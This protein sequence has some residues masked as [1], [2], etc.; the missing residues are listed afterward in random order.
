MTHSAA[1]PFRFRRSE[2]TVGLTEITSTTETVH[3]L[4]RLEGEL[5]RV[6]W[7][8]DRATERVGMSI[9]TDRE[10]EPVREVVL[11]L[12]ALAGARVAW[13]WWR[14]PPGL[15]LSLNAAD[16]RAFEEIAGEAGLRLDSPTELVLRVR[17]PDRL[18]AQE[19]AAELEM[20][21]AEHALRA[22][23]QPARVEG[24]EAHPPLPPPA[25]ARNETEPA[26]R[27]VPPAGTPDA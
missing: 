1:F 12:S 22:A 6:Q 14:W 2:D 23:E 9:R 10:V 15:Y 27:L 26:A 3:G 16:L 18:A 8:M 20:S 25:A 7:R 21:L 13:R 17:R 19:F 5:L 4:L 11:P 24:G